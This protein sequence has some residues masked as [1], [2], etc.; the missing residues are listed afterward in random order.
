MCTFK[1][2]KSFQNIPIKRIIIIHQSQPVL[3]YT[4]FIFRIS[5]HF[6][7]SSLHSSFPRRISVSN[8]FPSVFC[9]IHALFVPFHARIT[10]RLLYLFI[11]TPRRCIVFRWH[12]RD[13]FVVS[14]FLVLAE[15]TKTSLILYYPNSLYRR[16]LASYWNCTRKFLFSC[17][18]LLADSTIT[19]VSL[20]LSIYVI[21]RRWMIFRCE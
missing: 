1:F 14:R 20:A 11:S 21:P 17:T 5:F 15:A 4:H 19:L 2:C 18:F 10:V 16:R 12:C 7:Y 6:V 8:V 3:F 13:K 9:H